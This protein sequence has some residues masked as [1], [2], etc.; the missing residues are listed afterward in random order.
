MDDNLRLH[1]LQVT[2]NLQKLAQQYEWLLYSTGGALNLKK[3]HWVLISW[4]WNNGTPML[5]NILQAPGDL[6][7][8][9]GKSLELNAIPRLQPAESYRTLGAYINGSGKMTKA[10]ELSRSH[11]ETFAA[12]LR[13]ATLLAAAA[14]TAL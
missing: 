5:A 14:H 2:E 1:E 4:V 9:D 12:N 7:L 8:T 13:N 6:L 11:S 3:C 10:L